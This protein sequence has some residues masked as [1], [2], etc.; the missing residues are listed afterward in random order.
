MIKDSMMHYAISKSLK[1]NT[2]SVM[3]ELNEES[4]I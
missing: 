3:M 1:L 4:F 2:I